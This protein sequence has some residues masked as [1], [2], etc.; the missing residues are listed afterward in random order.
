MRTSPPLV[1]L[2]FSVACTG[3][4]V[5][6]SEENIRRAEIKT[7]KAEI[8]EKQELISARRFAYITEHPGLPDTIE[9][10]IL[11]GQII[12]RMTPEQVEATWGRPEDI[13]RHVSIYGTY[14]HWIYGNISLF[15]DDGILTSW[16]EY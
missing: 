5:G 8:Q 7:Q 10:A 11:N 15:F 6:V 12:L 14:E 4:L 3:C 9:R 2:L 16:S 1:L 13:H